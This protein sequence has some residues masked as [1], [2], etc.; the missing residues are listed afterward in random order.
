MET[1]LEEMIAHHKRVLQ[2]AREQADVPMPY[3]GSIKRREGILFSEIMID[4]LQRVARARNEGKLIAWVGLFAPMEIFHAMDIV[5]FV[6]EYFAMMMVYEKDIQAYLDTAAELGISSEVCSLHRILIGLAQ[7]DAV[8]SPD[9]IVSTSQ[10][11]DTTLKSY[12]FLADL[13]GCP[14]Y[15]LDFPYRDTDAGLDYY[16]KEV[17][18]LISFLEDQTNRQIDPAK[19][20]AVMQKSQIEDDL[21]FRISELK[22]SVPAPVNLRDAIRHFGI[23]LI[24]AGTQA[25]ITYF[26][27]VHDECQARVRMGKGASR[28]EKIRLLW[29]YVPILFGRL[30]EWMDR[31]FGA[32]V[33]MDTMNYVGPVRMNHSNPYRGLARKAYHQ[34]ITAQYCQPIEKFID[35]ILLLIE[36][37]RIDACIYQAHIG[38]KHGCATIRMLKDA[39]QEKCGIPFFT[40]DGDAMDATVVSVWELKDRLQGFLEMIDDL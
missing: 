17:K 29:L 9:I 26:K 37:F 39:V 7:T 10:T 28:K 16:E 19:L 38:C 6:V 35:D 34:F 12:E 18:G 25:G 15:F 33:V 2:Y 40:L 24:M 31:Q 5:P 27:S 32:V 14:A 3:D 4:Y 8:P 20:N 13:F 30:Y 22:K 23:H 21:Y 36:D 11:C 1:G